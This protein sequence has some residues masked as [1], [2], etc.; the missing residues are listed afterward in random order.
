V[1]R[2]FGAHCHERTFSGPSAAF[3]THQQRQA[4]EGLARSEGVDEEQ[5]QCRGGD[6][7]LDDDLAGA[8]P[9]FFLPTIEQD[10]QCGCSR[11]IDS[12]RESD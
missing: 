12:S 3:P 7:R 8:E 6:D 9:V 4:H 11:T 1:I 2:P 5:V 10:L